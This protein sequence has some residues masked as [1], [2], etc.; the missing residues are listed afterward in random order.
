M[1][2]L[3]IAEFAAKHPPADGRK[4]K[5]RLAPY[6]N[7]IHSLRTAGYTLAQIQEFLEQNGVVVTAAAIS[8]H[9]NPK[10]R[11]RAKQRSA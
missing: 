6:H 3:S 11:T 7:D 2:V 4:V 10:P 8:M 9:L 1:T 5:S